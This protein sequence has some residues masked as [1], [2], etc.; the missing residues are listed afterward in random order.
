MADL[1]EELARLAKT[2]VFGRERHVAFS[3]DELASATVGL[4]EVARQEAAVVTVVE[5]EEGKL[6]AT[7]AQDA[8]VQTAA[9][10]ARKA[11]V[12]EKV[13]PSAALAASPRVDRGR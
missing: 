11:N 6:A 9:A 8:A 2:A 3:Q 1:D 13:Q 4:E 7:H 10:E 5:V 12:N